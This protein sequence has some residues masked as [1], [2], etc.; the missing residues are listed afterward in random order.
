ME[1][2]SQLLH[3][4]IPVVVLTNGCI[5]ASKLEPESPPDTTPATA[6]SRGAAERGSFDQGDPSRRDAGEPTDGSVPSAARR[7]S[8]AAST[9]PKPA[10]AEP[11]AIER[12][13]YYEAEPWQGY[14][15]IAKTGKDTTLAASESFDA[16]TFGKPVC[17]RGSVAKAADSS[18]NAM[19]GINLN[20]AEQS[21]AAPKTVVP[22][23]AGVHVDVT[24]QGSSPLRVQVAGADGTSNPESRWCA[25]VSGSG[26]FIPWSAFN[27]ACWDGS[28]KPYRNEPITVAMLLVPGTAQSHV[29][30]DV[31]LARLTEADAALPGVGAAAGSGAA[32]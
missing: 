18:G 31:C 8:A 11:G 15:W 29:S 17:I 6:G 3:W 20:Q 7:D 2:M 26:G 1:S 23:R 12:G 32:P 9:Q 25:A 13:P 19:L 21:D 5:F 10:P 27:T 24:N 30:Y 4:A 16:A 28:G 14:F 22:T